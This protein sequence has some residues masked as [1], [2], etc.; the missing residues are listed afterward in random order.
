MKKKVLFLM[1]GLSRDQRHWGRFALDV[2]SELAD[3]EIVHLDLPGF[4]EKNNISSPANIKSIAQGVFTKELLDKYKDYDLKAIM[5]MSLGGMVT[6]QGV[7]DHPSF[8]DKICLLNSSQSYKTK[9]FERIAFGAGVT[10]AFSFLFSSLK[11]RERLIFKKTINSKMDDTT[12][13]DWVRF[14]NERPFKLVSVFKQVWAASR[15]S[16]KNKISVLKKFDGLILTSKSDRLVSVR[17]SY[18]LSKCLDWPCETHESGGHDLT[19]DDSA[20]VCNK[21]RAFLN[22]E[23]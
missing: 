15:F 10:L 14:F 6:L 1:R 21:L 12:V 17:A 4:G 8:F 7:C 5:A 3:F 23:L 11:S 18:V 16:I 19:F 2:K 9:R 22:K 13:A 20:W